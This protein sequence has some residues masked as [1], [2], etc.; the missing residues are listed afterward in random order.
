MR[1]RHRLHTAQS[2]LDPGG[3]I[4]LFKA[5]LRWHKSRRTRNP[6]KALICASAAADLEFDVLWVPGIK[7]SDGRRRVDDKSTG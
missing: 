3:G 7:A 4:D 1:G 6:W 5:Q 2:L